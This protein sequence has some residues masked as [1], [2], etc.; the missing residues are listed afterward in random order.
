M[1]GREFKDLGLSIMFTFGSKFI[2]QAVQNWKKIFPNSQSILCM[3]S[4]QCELD[5]EC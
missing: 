3:N 2:S 4:P 1:N 5:P